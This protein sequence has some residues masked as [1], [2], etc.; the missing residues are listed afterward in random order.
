MHL[1][2]EQHPVRIAIDGGGEPGAIRQ[3]RR[4]LVAGTQAEVEALER[5]GAAAAEPGR[6]RRQRA[7]QTCTQPAHAVLLS[8]LHQGAVWRAA[9]SAVSS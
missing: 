8:P 4:A 3:H 5:P 7:R 1:A 6:E 9:R 2:A